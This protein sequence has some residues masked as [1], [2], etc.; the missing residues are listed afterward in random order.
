MKAY[1]FVNNLFFRFEMGQEALYLEEVD[2]APAE[3]AVLQLL[4]KG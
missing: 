3:D 2:G 1:V 4:W